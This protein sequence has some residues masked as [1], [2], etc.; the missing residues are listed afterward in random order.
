[1]YSKSRARSL[2]FFSFYSIGVLKDERA[3]LLGV[4]TLSIGFLFDI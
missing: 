1:M 4:M 2:G 3:D